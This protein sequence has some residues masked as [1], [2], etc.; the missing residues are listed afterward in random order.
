MSRSLQ[1]LFFASC[2]AIYCSRVV[3]GHPTSHKPH[4]YR[5][6][7][8]QST[9]RIRHHYRPPML[10][11]SPSLAKVLL[12][13]ATARCVAKTDGPPALCLHSTYQNVQRNQMR[14]CTYAQVPS[15]TPFYAARQR[16]AADAKVEDASGEN[17]RVHPLSCA[18]ATSRR[19]HKNARQQN[20]AKHPCQNCATLLPHTLGRKK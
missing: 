2:L 16:F 15:A 3:Q 6:K 11:P 7:M 18:R 10:A 8:G 5:R 13:A 4:H 9:T 17:V 19:A 14:V 20:V 1:V 12:T